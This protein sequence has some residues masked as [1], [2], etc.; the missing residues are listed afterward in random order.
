MSRAQRDACA[1]GFTASFL[2]IHFLSGNRTRM[3][4]PAEITSI[5]V[6]PFL[7]VC[8][9]RL[10]LSRLS[11]SWS[12]RL[13]HQLAVLRRHVIQTHPLHAQQHAVKTEDG[14]STIN[15]HIAPMAPVVKHMRRPVSEFQSRDSIFMLAWEARRTGNTCTHVNLAANNHHHFNLHKYAMHKCSSAS[16]ETNE[17]LSR[18]MLAVV[19]NLCQSQGKR[20][21]GAR[22]CAGGRQRCGTRQ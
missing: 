21:P 13:L 1:K 3:L 7:S 20:V 16:E 15:S 18:R 12:S 11:G 22:R 2:P 14:R 19:C 17:N 4:C 5:M 8:R 6:R 10:G 9:P